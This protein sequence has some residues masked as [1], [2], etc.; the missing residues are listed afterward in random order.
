MYRTLDP[1]KI[2]ATLDQLVARIS[3]RFPGAG[4][5]RVCT[6]LKLVAA[7]SQART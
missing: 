5:A 2:V 4:L 7:E 1:D 3:E 6:E